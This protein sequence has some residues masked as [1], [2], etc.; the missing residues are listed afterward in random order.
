MFAGCLQL[1]KPDTTS[2]KSRPV[3]GNIF[4]VEAGKSK[5]FILPNKEQKSLSVG[6]IYDVH[7]YLYVGYDGK[8]IQLYVG[9]DLKINNDNFSC[10]I[11]LIEINKTKQSGV[12]QLKCW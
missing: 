2:I 12:F 8:R 10:N 9:Q 7:N 11:V 4:E 5:F 3:K 6:S 1:M